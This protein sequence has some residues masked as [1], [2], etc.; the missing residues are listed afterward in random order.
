MKKTIT[1]LILL[2]YIYQVNAQTCNADIPLTHPDSRF[3]VNSNGTVKDE[4]TGLIWQHCSAGQSWD[5][6]TNTCTGSANSYTWQNALMYAQNNTFAQQ[7]DWRLPN[8]KELNSIVELTCYSPAI[9]ETVFPN[10]ALSYYWSASAGAY[11][12][13]SAWIVNFNNGKDGN[14]S[15]NSNFNY[16]RVVRGGQ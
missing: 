8:I 9:N 11:S 4:Q 10:T 2:I 5:D 16:V 13:N 14:G 6:T 12:S 15:K 3:S 1:L 7:S